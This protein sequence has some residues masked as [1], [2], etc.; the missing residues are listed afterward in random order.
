MTSADIIEYHEWIG[1]VAK[2]VQEQQRLVAM[3]PNNPHYVRDTDKLSCRGY[4]LKGQDIEISRITG[5]I[6]IKPTL[7]TFAYWLKQKEIH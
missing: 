2:V 1:G 3:H 7:L 5:N 6:S 4:S